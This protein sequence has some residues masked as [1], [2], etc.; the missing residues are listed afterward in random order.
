[1]AQVSW[2]MGKVLHS[3]AKITQ[4]VPSCLS[5]MATSPGGARMTSTWLPE[6][7]V[8]CQSY[9]RDVFL[10]LAKIHSPWPHGSPW[11]GP[12]HSQEGGSVLGQKTIR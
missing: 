9:F 4:L 3:V 12:G 6:L 11:L 8:T 10:Y 7:H 2:A 1:M 5:F